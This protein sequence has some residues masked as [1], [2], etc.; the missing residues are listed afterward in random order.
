MEERRTGRSI[1]RK[2]Y[3]LAVAAVLII[4]QI[5]LMIAGWWPLLITNGG[6]HVE[7]ILLETV[8]NLALVWAAEHWLHIHVP[9]AGRTLLWGLLLSAPIIWLNI[10]QS[11]P[12]IWPEVQTMWRLEDFHALIPWSILQVVLIAVA[13]EVLFRGVV[14]Q[15][16]RHAL[17]GTRWPVFS[18]VVLTSLLF[19]L[20]HLNNAAGAPN[21]LFP[22]IYNMLTVFGW[23]LA[24]TMVMLLTR[25]LWPGMIV[26][27]LTDLYP[28]TR[29][30][31]FPGG[32]YNLEDHPFNW[33]QFT[34][35]GEFMLMG[36]AIAL[37]YMVVYLVIRRRHPQWVLTFA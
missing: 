15:L 11:L 1:P 14:F 10:G 3:W 6:Y 30:F 28:V 29:Q 9:F 27:F 34:A 18:T 35:A 5:V 8:V 20:M 36:I 24:V 7:L 31:A 19:A 12:D 22:T 23:A 21:F 32:M 13:E 16:L 37:V 26:H 4:E 25:S 33:A 17:Q 2:Y